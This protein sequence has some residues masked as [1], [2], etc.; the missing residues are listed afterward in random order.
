MKKTLRLTFP[1]WQGGV[2]P[3]YY[4]GSR[5]LTWLAPEGKNCGHRRHMCQGR[6]HA[7]AGDGDGDS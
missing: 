5:L 6:A 2:N 3:N 4:M 1:E 7:A